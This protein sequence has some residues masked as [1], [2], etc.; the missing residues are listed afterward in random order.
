LDISVFRLHKSGLLLSTSAIF[1]R[2]ISRPRSNAAVPRYSGHNHYDHDN[3]HDHNDNQH[4][5][6]DYD[7]DD[8]HGHHNIIDHDYQHIIDHDDNH[9]RAT[10]H[11]LMHMALVRRFSKMDQS[12]W[13]QR[14]LLDGV[15]MLLSEQQWH[16]GW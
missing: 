15:L 10:L 4:C 14:H 3:Q 13:R 5:A 7:N 11:W 6:A 1:F 16:N 12:L 8:Q 2:L 9:N